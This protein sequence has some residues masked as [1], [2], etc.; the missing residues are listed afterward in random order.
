ME[1]AMFG[2]QAASM[3]EELPSS[4][5]NW[6]S[7]IDKISTA[8]DKSNDCKIIIT[9]HT[10]ITYFASCNGAVSKYKVF[11]ALVLP[12]VTHSK[13]HKTL[14]NQVVQI[15]DEK[16][17]NM[18]ISPQANFSDP[19]FAVEIDKDYKINWR[20]DHIVNKKD[21]DISHSGIFPFTKDNWLAVSWCS[22]GRILHIQITPIR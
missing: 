17:F 14:P 22:T 4:I 1:A 15:S 7:V 19:F 13:G 2:A 18:T 21:A 6:W 9:N 11:S 8:S 20:T 3:V 12:A 10:Q 16:F 5:L